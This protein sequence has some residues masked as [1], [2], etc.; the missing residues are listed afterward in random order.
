[1]EDDGEKMLKHEQLGGGAAIYSRL[2]KDSSS[3][4]LE[5]GGARVDGR[6]LR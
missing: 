2:S 5:V 6:T 1:M 4:E 3:E